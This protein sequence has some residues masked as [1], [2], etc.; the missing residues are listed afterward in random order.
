[1]PEPSPADSA[2]S[3]D[4]IIPPPD[5]KRKGPN[6]LHSLTSDRGTNRYQR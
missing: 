5:I 3:A 2:S 6:N 1:M 4:V